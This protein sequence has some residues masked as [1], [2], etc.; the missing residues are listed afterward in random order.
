MGLSLIKMIK[1]V[2]CFLL[3]LVISVKSSHENSEQESEKIM[4]RFNGA[5]LLR[6]RRSSYDDDDLYREGRA[7]SANHF[8][9]GRKSAANH[10]LRGRKSEM[11]HFLRGRR[12]DRDARAMVNHLF[13]GKR[14]NLQG[15]DTYLDYL[16]NGRWSFEDPESSEDLK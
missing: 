2:V 6:G 11:N 7:L 16:L 15:D 4:K 13:R 12:F 3:F 5:H 9:R 10:F 1:L 14:R 8:L